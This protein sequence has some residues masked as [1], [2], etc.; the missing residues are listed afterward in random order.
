[1]ANHITEVDITRVRGDDYPLQVALTDEDDAA[2][3]I[4]TFTFNWTVDT[5][6]DPADELT[7]VFKV[8]GEIVVPA[9]D[10]VVEFPPTP[11]QMDLD[12]DTDYFYEIS[13]VD[14]GPF[15]RTIMRGKLIIEQDK[16]KT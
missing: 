5:I 6:E 4:D 14:T 15:K 7:Q 1:M 12:P 3:D 11:A 13:Q 9:T 10:G 16:D 8:A 2:I